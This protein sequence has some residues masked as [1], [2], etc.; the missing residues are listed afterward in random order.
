MVTAKK[1]KCHTR[2]ICPGCEKPKIVSYRGSTEK[3]EGKLI[4]KTCRRNENLPIG[5]CSG[6]GG[7]DKQLA[8]P[9]TPS[10]D[11]RVC[12]T[13]G[14]S[15]HENKEIKPRPCSKCRKKR[16]LRVYWPGKREKIKICST[17]YNEI[18]YTANCPECSEIGVCRYRKGNI[19]VCYECSKK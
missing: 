11:E 19:R 17:C 6:C 12:H 10:S 1:S 3:T 4:C 5:T 2:Q 13:C 18:K 9:K 16:K 7:E 14:K 8:Y 15:K